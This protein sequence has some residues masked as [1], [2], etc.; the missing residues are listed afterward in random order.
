MGVVYR[1]Y[2]VPLARTGAVKVM[3]G[4]SPDPETITRFRREAQAIAQ[5]RHPNILNVFDYGEYQ[6]TPYM[7]VEYVPGGSLAAQMKKGPMDAATTIEYLEGIAAGLDYAHTLGI[8]H[9][10]VKPANVLVA[11]DGTPIIADFGLV[12]LLQS[13]SLHS[14]TGATTGTPAYMAPEQVTGSQVGP[15]ADRYSLATMAYEMLTGTFPFEDDSV[16]EMMYAHVHRDPAPPSK[17]RPELGSGVDA[18][19]LRGLSRDPNARWE[20][21]D[22]FVNAL[23]TALEA[24]SIAAVERTAVMAP[25]V[26]ATAPIARPKA[27]VANATVVMPLSAPAAA[28]ATAPM[29]AARPATTPTKGTSHRRRNT[30]LAS[31]VLLLLLVSTCGLIVALQ[32]TTLTLSATTV[33]PGDSLVA[34]AA[35]VPR[36]QT[37]E[38]Q[39]LSRVTVFPFRAD[40]GGN[41]TREITVPGDTVT[42]DHTVR[43]CWN[44]TCHAQAPLKVVDGSAFVGPP[45]FTPGASPSSSPSSSATPTSHGA[46]TPTSGTGGT[47]TTRPSPIPTRAPSPTPTKAPSPPPPPPPSPSPTPPPNPCPTSTQSALLTVSPATILAGLTTVTVSGQNFTP[48]KQVTVSYYYPATAGSPNRTWNGTVGC[49]G[50]FSSTF[51][52]GLLDIGTAKV[53]AS[54]AGGRS[55][56]KSFSIT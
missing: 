33:R 2:H 22:A 32:P 6:G 37:G 34:T 21:C 44:G 13:A 56:S 16:L 27:A 53:T 23:R 42:G 15:A 47:G 51:T 28:V 3:H 12:K 55:A 26:A 25:P 4:I 46:P 9:R 49:N 41:V 29:P 48:N 30:I 19:I 20:S 40:A 11:R 5:M 31:A 17:W 39:L 35:H 1:A 50:T 10:D 36:N 45:T 18:V 24:P 43:I 52:P 38:I 8:I 14:M 54:D 7:I